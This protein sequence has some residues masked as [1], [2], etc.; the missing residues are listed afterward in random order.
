VI[1]VPIFY[2]L[3]CDGRTTAFAIFSKDPY[4]KRSKRDKIPAAS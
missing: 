1:R 2:L 3:A 4:S